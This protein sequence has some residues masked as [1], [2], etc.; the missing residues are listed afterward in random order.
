MS[1]LLRIM[2]GAGSN[3]TRTTHVNSDY[4]GK[5]KTYGLYIVYITIYN[6]ISSSNYTLFG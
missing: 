5:T 6:V 1:T 2:G 3:C 4:P